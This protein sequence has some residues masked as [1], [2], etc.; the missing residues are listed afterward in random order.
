MFRSV[1]DC[2]ENLSGNINPVRPGV[3]ADL[4]S[5]HVLFDQNGGPFDDTRTDDKESSRNFLLI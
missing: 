4:M 1:N 3:H 2:W 5:S